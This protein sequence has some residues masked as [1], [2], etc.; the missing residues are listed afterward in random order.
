[1]FDAAKFKQRANGQYR[2]VF[3]FPPEVMTIGLKVYVGTWPRRKTTWPKWRKSCMTKRMNRWVCLPQRWG[4]QPWFAKSDSDLILICWN[5]RPFFTRSSGEKNNNC[6]QLLIY[7]TWLCRIFAGP[8]SR[9]KTVCH[10]C[11]H[12]ETLDNNITCRIFHTYKYL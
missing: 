4:F 9:S 10:H 6:I 5:Y 1:M 11:H 8:F 7:A 2:V 12:C 3:P